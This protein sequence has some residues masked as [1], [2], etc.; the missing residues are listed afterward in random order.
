MKKSRFVR[1]GTKA[2]LSD[3]TTGNTKQ[4]G[5]AR[6]FLVA[7]GGSRRVL[8]WAGFSA[9]RIREIRILSQNGPGSHAKRK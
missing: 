3:A 4:G 6:I 2:G 9:N 5:A 1:P 8:F 7:L